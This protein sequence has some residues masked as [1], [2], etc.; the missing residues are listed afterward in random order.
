MEA[1]EVGIGR[2]AGFRLESSSLGLGNTA[3]GLVTVFNK[4]R[5]D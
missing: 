5:A 1:F 4:D 2:A 3:T